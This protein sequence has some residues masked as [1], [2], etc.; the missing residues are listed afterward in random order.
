MSIS[1]CPVVGI[2]A[3]AGGLASL[4]SLFKAMPNDSGA[5]F[6]VIQHLDPKHESLTAEILTRS[7]TMPVVQVVDGMT[8]EANHVYVIP[9]NAYLTLNDYNF[10]LDKPVLHHGLRMPIDTF[11]WS[12]A[13]QHEDHAIAIIVSGTG[14]DGTLGLRAI[15]GSGG[16]VLAQSPDSAEYDGMPRSAIATGL[17]DITCPIQEMPEHIQHYLRHPYIRKIAI[18]KQGADIPTNE[19]A[20][21]SAILALLQSKTGHDFRVYKHGIFERRIARR[22]GL[23][24]LENMEDYLSF[25]RKHEDETSLLFKNLLIGVTT[26][27]RDPEAFSALEQKVLV[28]L[29]N[30]KH[31]DETIRV[32]IPGC[33]TGEEAYSIAML[34][35]EQLEETNKH[36]SIQVFASDIDEVALGVGRA[37]LYPE[38]IAGGISEKRLQRFFSKEDRSY[39]VNKSLRELVTFASQNL[40]SDP[41]FSNLDLIS[42]R[43]LLI[44]LS[45]DVQSKVLALFHFALRKNG[46]LFLGHSETSS[47][48]DRLFK[49]IAKKWRIYKRSDVDR[50]TTGVDFPIGSRMVRAIPTIV[51]KQG[52]GADQLRLGEVA[53]QYLLQEFAPAAVLVNT[54]HQILHFSGSTSRYLEQPSG[55]PS[56]DL[57]VLAKHELRGKLRLAIRRV[58]EEKKRVVIDDVQ[59][60]K[61][62]GRVG[63][64]ISLRP[65]KI[66]QINEPLILITFEDHRETE[67]NPEIQKNQQSPKQQ[68]SDSSLIQQMETELHITRE[69]LQS[70]IEEWESANEELQAA[71]EEMM[72]VNEE[73]QSSNEELESSKEELQS[74]NEELTTVNNQYKEKVEELAKINDDLDN[75]LSS[76]NIATLFIDSQLRIGRFTPATQKLLNLI[77]TDV[78][79]PISDI[80]P[81]FTDGA[82]MGDIKQVLDV[83]TSVECEISTENDSYYLRRIQPYRTSGNRIAGV[84]ITFIDISQRKR[85]EEDTLRLAT[86]IR[87]SNDAV[88]LCNVD[89]KITAWNTGAQ[90]M[91][92]WSEQQAM[93]MNVLDL[94]PKNERKNTRQLLHSIVKGE[95]IHGTESLRVSKDGRVITVLLT[96]TPL[97]DSDGKVVSIA[98]TEKDISQRI[99]AENKLRASE[100]SFRALVESAPDALVIVNGDGEIEVA[101]SQAERLFGYSKT[102]LVG[103]LVET[104]MPAIFAAKHAEHRQAFFTHPKVRLVG[105]GIEVFALT[106]NGEE[107]PIEV[108][109][110]TIDTDHGQV[111]SAAIRDIRQRKINDEAL[112][113]AK[114][115][116][117]SALSAKSRFLATASHDLRQPLH[118]LT[119][120]NKA[121]LKSINQPEARKMLGIQGDSLFSMAR[122]LNSLLDISKL[123]SGTVAT[124]LSNF[125]LH[126]ML[127]KLCAEFE[128]EAN[129]NGLELLL[130]ANNKNIV[131]SDPGLLAQLLQNLLANAIRYTKA[132]KVCIATHQENKELKISISDTG[133]GI[134]AGQ[135]SHIFDEFHQLDRNPQQ[136]HGGLGLG[137]SIVQ[138]IAALLNTQVEVISEMGRGSTFS[139]SLPLGKSVTPVVP[140]KVINS[141]EPTQKSALVLLVDDDPDVLD[142]SEMLLSMEQGFK[143]MCA[144]SPQEAYAAMEK[145]L[146]DLIITDFHLN[147]QESGLDIINKA[148]TK[149]GYQIPAI[150][151]SGDTSP[152]VG[153]ISRKNLE[154]MTKPIDPEDLITK[155]RRL[156]DEAR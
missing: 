50:S 120:L 124:Q 29:M 101:N 154:V 74:M 70:N 61:D 128:A 105:N 116:A 153:N 83:L 130:K 95:V 103:M 13:E 85:A 6:V 86:V 47:Q 40:I 33:A 59:I 22:M 62:H 18:S 106:K 148:K 35:V 139:I 64:N 38:N 9:P 145:R 129:E 134:P 79:R 19:R 125:A 55:S 121:L 135:L 91:Y 28:P 34:L 31:S 97:F 118:S 132:G 102:E 150:L 133:V 56:H 3:S 113:T 2:G 8:A 142:A 37:G 41:P 63:L 44:Y 52:Y 138:R 92:G 48:Q 14:G 123:E 98:S 27:F 108:G 30:T 39:R 140:K 100:V 36:C 156:L 155:A 76:T 131:H 93:S 5:V 23:H 54:R 58:T 71:N 144:T 45:A 147:H 152:E 16:L 146:P 136:R 151:V 24:H 80:R 81:K 107:I 67:L 11:L 49:P 90:K 60:L 7:T 32:W 84:V 127:E 72:S 94:V 115:E 78:G 122:L 46:C 73:L 4:K 26:F 99:Q 21:L 77:P 87:D 111:V 12:L 141:P 43:N 68:A 137:L 1:F 53:Q 110:S 66:P 149:D 82:L 65:L 57:L 109:L 15:K 89:G 17:V 88:T 25:L 75:L 69:D 51:G 114:D 20:Q 117:E 10:I 96:I 112:R 126:P 42:C 104:L 119:L 143:I